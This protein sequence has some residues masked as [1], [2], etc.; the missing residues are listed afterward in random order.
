[1]S[2]KKTERPSRD[3]Q[4]AN[5]GK[6]HRGSMTAADL[7]QWNEQRGEFRRKFVVRVHG[8]NRQA[9]WRLFERKDLALWFFLKNAL[10]AHGPGAARVADK[11]FAKIC[12]VTL[13]E[14]DC[15]DL[16]CARARISTGQARVIHDSYDWAA[17]VDIDLPDLYRTVH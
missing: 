16:E 5:A 13:F 10:A 6:H 4:P 11:T 17:G 1:M 3:G 9:D 2:E 14:V 8:E 15:D 12:W 7:A